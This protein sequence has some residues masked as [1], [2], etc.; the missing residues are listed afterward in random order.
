[1][2]ISGGTDGMDR[3]TG[4]IDNDD[5]NTLVYVVIV[6]IIVVG[7]LAFTIMIVCLWLVRNRLKQ[8]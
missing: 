8:Q 3:G 5:D 6:L 7:L 4:S 2:G 1:M